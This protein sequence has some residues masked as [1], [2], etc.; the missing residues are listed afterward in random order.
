MNVRNRS[1]IWEIKKTARVPQQEYSMGTGAARRVLRQYRMAE[2]LARFP[3]VSMVQI[4][5][6]SYTRMVVVVARRGRE[7]VLPGSM[8]N[9]QWRALVRRWL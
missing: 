2:L 6:V 3:G 1:R 8:S 4:V 7:H 9:R 5:P